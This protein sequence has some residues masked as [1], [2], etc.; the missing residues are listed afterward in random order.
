MMGM[1][2]DSIQRTTQTPLTTSLIKTGSQN[3][4]LLDGFSYVKPSLDYNEMT[5]NKMTPPV[6]FW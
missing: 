6:S 4:E 2:L 1:A 3:S 5:P